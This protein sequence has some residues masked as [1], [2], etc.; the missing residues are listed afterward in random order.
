MQHVEASVV[1]N[2]HSNSQMLFDSLLG[3][4]ITAPLPPLANKIVNF[5]LA[6]PRQ[7]LQTQK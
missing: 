7:L 6:E 4:I 2:N 5:L 3:I 1:V